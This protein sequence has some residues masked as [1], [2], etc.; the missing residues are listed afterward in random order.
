M[1]YSKCFH[2]IVKEWLLQ[3]LGQKYL[4]AICVDDAL[5]VGV[6]LLVAVSLLVHETLLVSSAQGGDIYEKYWQSNII[7]SD[8]DVQSIL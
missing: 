2:K 5:F 4:S 3:Q 7:L 1:K 6:A 8:G